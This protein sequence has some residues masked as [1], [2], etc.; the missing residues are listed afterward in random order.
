MSGDDRK[1]FSLELKFALDRVVEYVTGGNT[2]MLIAASLIKHHVGRNAVE[3]WATTPILPLFE[4]YMSVKEFGGLM[5]ERFGAAPDADFAEHMKGHPTPGIY[6]LNAAEVEL[7]DTL[8]NAIVDW[9]K[10]LHQQHNV[11]LGVN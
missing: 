10:D 11:V 9:E 6:E 1:Y 8:I 2:K 5:R 4:Y 3:D 7:I